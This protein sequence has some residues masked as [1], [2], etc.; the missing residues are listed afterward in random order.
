MTKE[1][2]SIIVLNWNRVHYSKTTIEKIIAKTTV[3]HILVLVDNNSTKESGV[4]DYLSSINKSNTN[5][6]D[7]IHVF[8]DT[9]LGVAGGRNSG[10]YAVEQSDYTQKYI[11]NIDDDVVVPNDWDKKIVEVCDKVPK[12]GITGINVEPIKYTVFSLNGVKVQVKKAGNLGGAALCL[13]RRVFKSVGYYGF[14]KGTLYG[15]EDSYM[16][17]KLDILGLMSAYITGQGIH[18]DKDKDK[19]Y[20]KK[21]ND[22]HKKGSA[23][24]RELSRSVLEMRRT[25]NVYTPYTPPERYNPVDKD[26]FTNDLIKKG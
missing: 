13:P 12:I 8:N 17:S 2:M 22:A 19:E 10:I 3:P 6:E 1:V 14:G 4:K 20:R 7:V 5:A 11:F 16:R 18:L 21:K 23:Q 15:H 9:N 24:L 26:I 25:K